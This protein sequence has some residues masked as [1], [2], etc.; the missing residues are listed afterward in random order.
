VLRPDQTLRIE[1]SGEVEMARADEPR[2]LY[3]RV[4]PEGRPILAYQMPD[5]SLPMLALLARVGNGP[6]FAVGR[7]MELRADSARAPGEL[8]FGPN[9]DMLTDNA[10]SW[11]VRLVLVD[12]AAAPARASTPMPVAA[13]PRRR[14]R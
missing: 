5:P 7:G 2:A 11:T 1:V 6:T 12:S 9:D 3:H 13:P 10:R 8:V 4:P 14:G